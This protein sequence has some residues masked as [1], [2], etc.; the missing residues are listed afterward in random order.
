MANPPFNELL[1]VTGNTTGATL[2]LGAASAADQVN[3]QVSA[4]A[5]VTASQVTIQASAD[6]FT[7]PVQVAV[8]NNAL[9]ASGTVRLPDGYRYW[10]AVLASY[11][12]TG[13]VTCT[14]ELSKQN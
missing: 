11:A 7:T 12:G 10:R 1:K 14:A 8:V 3:F 5:T 6:N 13:T 9:H 4:P 2:D